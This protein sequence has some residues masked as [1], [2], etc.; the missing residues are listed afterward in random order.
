MSVGLREEQKDSMKK[1]RGSSY[2]FIVLM[3]MALVVIVP[4]LGLE[5]MKSQLLP[6]MMGGIVFVLSAVA[7]VRELLAKDKP[8]VTATGGEK[9]GRE[10]AGEGLRGHL[11]IG[12]WVVGFVLGIYLLSFMIAIPIF[13]LAY[14]KSHGVGW[15]RAIIFAVLIAAIVYGV[16][17]FALQV[18]LHRGLLFIWLRQ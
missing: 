9:S 15:I 17:E 14:M 6:I 1:M 11:P 18:E 8:E 4:S 16:F 2:F 5:D 12:A 7:L 10:E 3:V 13:I